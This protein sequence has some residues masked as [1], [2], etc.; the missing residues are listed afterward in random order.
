MD[1]V[2]RKSVYRENISLY[3]G[4]KQVVKHGLLAFISGG[5]L[6]VLGQL[7]A[8]GYHYFFSVSTERATSYMLVSF[9]GLAALATGLGVYRKWA[10]TFGAGLLVPIVGFVNAM[11]SAAIEHK[12]EGFFIGIGPQL[13]RLVGPIIVA[14]IACAYVLSFAR[15]LIKVFIQ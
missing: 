13:F 5:M 7:V 1:R 10:Q 14:G 15:L 9:I 8:S 11:A 2:T 12:S 3:R 4:K 6:C